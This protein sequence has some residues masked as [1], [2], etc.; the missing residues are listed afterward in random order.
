MTKG[1][2]ST[3][4]LGFEILIIELK[5]GEGQEVCSL[6]MNS[7]MLT[8]SQSWLTDWIKVAEG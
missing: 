8:E 3:I 6:E 7:T 1:E 5:G 4:S 2:C